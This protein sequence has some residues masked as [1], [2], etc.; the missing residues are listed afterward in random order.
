MFIN[1]IELS[2]ILALTA[3]AFAVAIAWTPLLTH[4]LYKFNL[5]KQ[6]RSGGKTPIFTSLHQHKEGTP[7][8]G[9]ILIWGTVFLLLAIFFVINKFFPESSFAEFNFLDRGQ[10]YL[11]LAALGAAA[12]V[13]LA[14]DLFGIWRIGPFGGG[15]RMRHRLVSYGAIA[16]LG[17]WWF[18][19]KLDWSIIHIPF[20]GEFNIGWWYIPFFI[21][22]IVA[23][24]FSVNETDGLDGLAGGV[25]VLSFASY[26]ILAFAEGKYDLAA[27]IAVIIGALLAFLWFNI[28]PARFFM[29]DTGSMPLGITLGIIAMLTNQSLLLPLIGFILVME[30]ASVIVQL[31][32]KKVFK[33][34]IFHSTPIHHHFE[35]IGWPESKIVMRFWVIS[36]VMAGMGIIVGLIG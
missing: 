11:P 23:T 13:G 18:Y 9:G 27:L 1:V 21:F 33:R 24:S 8:M 14:D 12:I 3:I 15:L 35:A 26:A 16:I 17:A 25:L 4:F 32:S 10:T 22:I 28:P 5:G 7:T 30:S 31:T 2:R 19:D 34:K 20:Y 6:I 29:G 36:A